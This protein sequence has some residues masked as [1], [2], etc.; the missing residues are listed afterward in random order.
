MSDS[1]K[2]RS[3]SFGSRLS[4]FNDAEEKRPKPAFSESSA[5]HKKVISGTQADSDLEKHISQGGSATAKNVVIDDRYIHYVDFDKKGNKVDKIAE[6]VSETKAGDGA[7]F[8]HRYNRNGKLIASVKLSKDLERESSNGKLSKGVYDGRKTAQFVESLHDKYD[9]FLKSSDEE[10]LDTKLDDR[11]ERFLSHVDRNIRRKK[12][13]YH[14]IKINSKKDIKQIKKEFK[15]EEKHNRELLVDLCF[16]KSDSSFVSESSTFFGVTD[17]KFLDSD[18][19]KMNSFV[20]AASIYGGYRPGDFISNKDNAAVLSASLNNNTSPYISGT[21]VPKKNADSISVS[22]SAMFENDSK[23]SNV[24]VLPFAVLD[25]QAIEHRTMTK[26]EMLEQKK[27]EKK[28]AKKAEKKQIRKQAVVTSVSNMLETKKNLS[29]ELMG[30]GQ[31]TGDLIVDGYSGVTKTIGTIFFNEVKYYAG[32]AVRQVGKI[33]AKLLSAIVGIIGNVF[34]VAIIIAIPLLL[35]SMFCSLV[36]GILSSFDSEGEYTLSVNSSNDFVGDPLSDEEI[37]VIMNQLMA[38]YNLTVEQRNA[39]QYALRAVGCAY[40][41]D[42][43]GNHSDKVYDCSELA[44]LAMQKAGVDIN[45]VGHV[46]ADQAKGL[47]QNGYRVD[48][49]ESLKPGD[50]IFYSYNVN[51]RYKNIS[52][53]AIYMGKVNGVDRMVEAANETQGVIISS[54]N[55]NNIKSICRPLGG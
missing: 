13:R 38:Q 9:V 25:A 37:E 24:E 20:T 18:S 41:Q 3:G 44:Y 5:V 16:N 15:E 34:P 33:L 35:V 50:L 7:E 8:K 29:N 42:S 54:V 39:L 55:P 2:D 1:F 12:N 52:H 6:R 10:T 47:E 17:N 30:N 46:A 43:H 21:V 53:V 19:R 51:G 26:Q 27:A 28:A 45:I 23:S 40:D 11:S 36:K 31:L 32:Y 49:G 48:D 14:S 4:A 22:S